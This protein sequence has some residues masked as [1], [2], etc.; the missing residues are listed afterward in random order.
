MFHW[1]QGLQIKGSHFVIFVLLFID[2]LCTW[3]RTK[4]PKVIFPCHPCPDIH[5]TFC[6]LFL[7]TS[8]FKDLLSSFC[9]PHKY[10][11][12]QPIYSQHISAGYMHVSIYTPEDIKVIAYFPCTLH[13]SLLPNTRYHTTFIGTCKLKSW[14]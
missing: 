9:G 6:Y 10:R 8:L 5:S 2:L 4:G 12:K 14:K 11:A 7:Y 3:S 13:C 1:T